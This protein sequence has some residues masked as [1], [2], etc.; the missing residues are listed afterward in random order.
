MKRQH[1]DA[2]NAQSGD[3]SQQQKMQTAV[4]VCLLVTFS[5]NAVCQCR[6]AVNRKTIVRS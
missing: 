2:A 1:L 4:Q 3:Q 5:A 6:L